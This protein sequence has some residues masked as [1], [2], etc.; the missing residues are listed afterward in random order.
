MA[1]P[2][3]ARGPVTPAAMRRHPWRTL[4]A[5]LALA[6]VVLVLLWDWNWFR[7]PL[8]RAVEAR[9][10]RT[11]DILGDLD[12][13]LGWTTTTVR[14]DRIRFGNAGWSRQPLMAQAER[15]ELDLAIRPLFA[16]R[17]VIPE[18]RLTRPQ[19]L[20]EA[21]PS[22]KGGNWQ[23]GEPGEAATEFRRLLVERGHLRYL[24]ARDRT[25]VRIG[26][27]SIAPAAGRDAAIALVGGGRFRGNAFRIEG[28]AAPPLQLRDTER[29][30]RIDVRAVAGATRAHARGTLLDPVRLRDFDL[31]LALSGKNL[32]DLYPLL[33]LSMP[34]TP[35][36]SVDGRLGRDIRGALTTWRYHDFTGR[37]G[38][39]D[40]AGDVDVTTGGPRPFFKGDL[41]SR[42]LDFDDLAGFVGGAP[43]PEETTNPE[44][45]ALAAQRRASPRLLPDTPY[46]LDKLRA[47]DADVRLRAQ[48]IDAPKLPLERMDAHLTLKAGLLRLDPLDFGMADGRIRSTV[49]LDARRSPIRTHADIDATRLTLAKLLPNVKLASDA[50]GRVGGHVDLTGSGNSI[51]AMLGSSDGSVALGMG[52]GQISNLLMEFAGIDVAEIV[53]FKLTDDRKVPV[54]CAF[55]DFEVRDGVM[56]TRALAFDTTDTIVVGSGT[57]DLGEER[58]DLTLRPRPKDRS[59]LALRTPL[60]VEG[61][62]KQPRVRPDYGR[63]GLRGAIALA[64]GTITPPAALLATL[65]LGPGENADCGGRYAK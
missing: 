29:P 3:P 27:H 41:H 13:D 9:T 51:A 53:K 57:I 37:V 63:L 26:V 25:D 30:Y 59:L 65:E 50:V 46:R 31:R 61:A 34:P 12:V 39:S 14:L 11:F 5:L 55:A 43:R 56:K 18:L 40:L 8:E 22:G 38:D 62:F 20:L 48:R 10:G 60:Y 15:V 52:K 17:V 49:T 47:M 19:L 54:R 32:E 21:H 42:R 4:L 36:Y 45:A 2:T 24:S 33:G 6:L 23:F 44:L 64:L 58:L 16:R 35:P 28:R 1:D 7:R